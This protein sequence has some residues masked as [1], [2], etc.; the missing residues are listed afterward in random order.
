MN[1]FI[2]DLYDYICE[3]AP[4]V[5]N[6]PEYKQAVKA[7]EEIEA[8]VREKTGEDLLAEYQRAEWGCS[9]L[10]ELAVFRQTL[11]FCQHFTL[12]TLR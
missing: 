12:E 5:R 10:R 11:R 8:E 3:Q 2:S 6:D 7:Y 9:R 4:S 1:D